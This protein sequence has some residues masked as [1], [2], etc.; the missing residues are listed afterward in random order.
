MLDAT[1]VQELDV[2]GFQGWPGLSRDGLEIYFQA[3]G[4]NEGEIYR[5]RRASTTA[6]WGTPE[7]VPELS[8]GTNAGDPS[9]SADG[10]RIYLSSD[11]PGSGFVDL[12]VATCVELEDA[13]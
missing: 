7:P 11:S 8:P 9:L 6:P 3:R 4:N 5:A 2:T 12:H 10:T 13:R 1:F